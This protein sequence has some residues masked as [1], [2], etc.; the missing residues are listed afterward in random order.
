MARCGRSTWRE[1]ATR[2]TDL[3]R[4]SS[5]WNL[6]TNSSA[7]SA[8]DAVRALIKRFE[9]E[10]DRVFDKAYK[11]ANV[12]QDFLDPFFKALGWDTADSLEVQHERPV[13]MKDE[14]KSVDSA[15][16][17]NNRVKFMVEAKRPASKLEGNAEYAYQARRYGWNASIP[18]VILS[19]FE[20][21][22]V[23]DTTIRPK[24]SDS[25]NV[26][27]IESFTYKDYVAK[28]DFLWS[29][30]SRAA[31]HAGSLEAW[32]DEVR[33]KQ[34]R[35]RVDEALLE[36]VEAWRIHLAKRIIAD[37]SLEPHQL[38]EVVQLLLDRILFL[39][40][41]EDRGLEKSRRLAGLLDG[42]G[43]YTRLKEFFRLAD[44][45]YNAGLF[46]LEEEKGRGPPDV[47]SPKLVVDDDALK[48]VIRGLYDKNKP[49]NFAVIPT[50]ILGQV[51]ERFLGTV[52]RVTAS[53]ERVKPE[54]KPEVKEAGGV[55]YTPTYIVEHIV[56]HTLGPLVDGKT[57]EEVSTLRIV[58]PACGSGSFLLGAYQFLLDWHLA[59][60]L[61]DGV[62]K[63]PLQLVELAP[64]HWVL[65]VEER[66]RILRNNIY[67]VDIDRQATEVT[68][69]SLFLKVVEETAGVALE[70]NQKLFEKRVLPSMEWNIKCGNSLVEP[71]HV[72]QQSFDGAEM[73][74][75]R[76]VNAFSWK[77][78]FGP[79]MAKGG[80]DAVIGN[81]PYIRVQALNKFAPLE[82]ELYK[83]H[84][85]TAAKGNYD[86]YVVFV[87]R[88]L[89]LLNVNG[90]LGY[91]LP[92]KFFN[93]HYGEALRNLIA[94][95][96][97]IDSIVHFGDQ[98]VFDEA[99][100]YTCLLFL[101][102][103]PTK[104]FRV[105]KVGDLSAWRADGLGDEAQVAATS[106]SD[107]GWNFHVGESA[108][109]MDRLSK[110]PTTLGDFA[111]RI[112]Q[113]LVTGS[114]PVFL[115]EK[116]GNRYYSE[117]TKKEYELEETLL[118]DLCKG[119]V[120][121]R[122][123]RIEGVSRVIIFPYFIVEDKAHLISPGEFQRDFPK[124]WSYLVE[125][126][127]TLE[128]RERGKWKHEKWYAL[129]RSQNLT[130]MNQAKILTP[131][132]A[133]SASFSLDE[134]GRYYFVGSGG[135]GGGGYGITLKPEVGLAYEYILGLLNSRLLDAVLK[136]TSS[137]FRGG[138]FAY[139][140][141]YIEQLPIRTIDFSNPEDRAQH[142]RI[143]EL[144]HANLLLHHQLVS[145][146][147]SSDRELIMRQIDATDEAIDNL[148]FDLYEI[149]ED[150]RKLIDAG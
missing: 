138:Y 136:A 15:F 110:V 92:H 23:Y 100:T 141:Q 75:A 62:K 31:V 54:F 30:F 129:G 76:R 144:V 145:R 20:E 61:K 52:L 51:Y 60:Y 34:K 119:S 86:I 132:I 80:F 26:A 103:E 11:E 19:D 44:Q 43:V 74:T 81:P 96:Q 79:I 134:E 57:P 148:V 124:T 22:V 71:S 113:G 142:D 28:W 69:L 55:F 36:D 49:Y 56:K 70:T 63:H 130:E 68:K 117:A 14:T 116:R 29:K 118:H 108:R 32:S 24:E 66:K 10:R 146:E 90:R 41:C 97:H 125:C 25:A 126:R 112:F 93:A 105:Q 128:E 21:F 106:V 147:F 40:I 53:G 101:N 115:L 85:K 133:A 84:Y 39:R 64:K 95:G 131:S 9:N 91:I 88:A 123:Y 2:V 102:K 109:L 13:K 114:D 120:N 8:L 122:R 73:Q 1:G 107:A 6:V 135:G 47:I 17:L 111:D 58:D 12:R 139:N 3:F 137:Q 149:T 94:S 65:S 87:E 140:R 16:K 42:G 33:G 67:G 150:E 7:A 143:V 27:R 46:Y 77:Q 50:E 104:A 18:F 37:N 5:I 99:T 45:K 38:P 78:A 4:D 98:Q 127:S 82:V 121:L 48:E 59:W 83:K 72:P 89:Q 35:I